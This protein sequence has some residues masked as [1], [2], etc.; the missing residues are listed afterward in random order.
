[1]ISR[2]RARGHDDH[3]INIDQNKD[4]KRSN[5]KNKQGGSTF[6]AKKL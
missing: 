2:R 5:V 3:G 4:T 1:M 6:E